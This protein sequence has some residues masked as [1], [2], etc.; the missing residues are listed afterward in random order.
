[1]IAL[2]THVVAWLH[3]GD[4]SRLPPAVRRRLDSEELGVS[5]IVLLE[6]EYLRKTGRLTVP[7]D[8]IL[9]DLRQAIGLKLLTEPFAAVVQESLRHTWTRDPFDRLISAHA[10]VGGYDLATKDRTIRRHCKAAFW[11]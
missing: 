2:D 1:M 6:L 10:L 7:A 11:T 3:A 9:A 4:L 5:P 8:S